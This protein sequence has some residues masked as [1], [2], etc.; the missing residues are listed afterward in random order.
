MGLDHVAELAEERSGLDQLDGLL[1]AL[2]GGLDDANRI[3]VGLGSIT[4]IV[5]LVQVAVVALMIE[6]HIE[7]DNVAIEQDAL[8]GYPVADDLVDRGAYRLGEVVVV[9]G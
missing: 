5:R 6:R 8:I 9:Q 3:G 2:A 7:V 4:N 1:E